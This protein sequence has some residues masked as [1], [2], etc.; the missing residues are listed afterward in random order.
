MNTF[1][2]KYD[3]TD[4]P[5]IQRALALPFEIEEIELE[6][7]YEISPYRPATFHDP[8]EGGYIEDVEYNILT[9]N[10][11]VQ[12]DKQVKIIMDF[13]DAK[14][15]REITNEWVWDDYAD[16]KNEDDRDYAEYRYDM[17]NDKWLT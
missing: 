10:K 15:F 7:S 13:I 17:M 3:T 6:I 12:N 16:K 5:E 11:F 9:V 8:A 1:T 14:E 4:Y 2:K